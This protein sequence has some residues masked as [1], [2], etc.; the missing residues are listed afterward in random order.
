[1]GAGALF[2]CIIVVSTCPRFQ[3]ALTIWRGNHRLSLPRE[4]VGEGVTILI[5]S[6]GNLQAQPVPTA[7]R[8]FAAQTPH[9]LEKTREDGVGGIR[10][11]EAGVSRD[12]IY[13]F[14]SLGQRSHAGGAWEGL[15][16]TFLLQNLLFILKGKGFWDRW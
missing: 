10:G 4:G 1:M 3:G 13:F 16:S 9:R 5:I 12:G 7:V 14:Q 11:G 2:L 15:V 6:F 8:S